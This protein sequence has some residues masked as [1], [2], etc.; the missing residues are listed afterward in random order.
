M[1][2]S[3]K[4][5]MGYTSGSD[6]DEGEIWGDSYKASSDEYD[7]PLKS[8]YIYPFI[9]LHLYHP[10]LNL[11]LSFILYFITCFNYTITVLYNTLMYMLSNVHACITLQCICLYN[12][13]LY[14]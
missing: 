6:S 11:P 7:S 9:N 5:C 14:M 3:G 10:P 1:D 12:T 13:L 2:S 4:G 8:R